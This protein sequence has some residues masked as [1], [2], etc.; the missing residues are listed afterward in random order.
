MS[1]EQDIEEVERVLRFILGSGESGVT[2]LKL[3]GDLFLSDKKAQRYID[4][5]TRVGLIECT[6]DTAFY[7]IT[8]QGIEW[9]QENEKDGRPLP[10]H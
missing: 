8:P 3:M 2:R 4:L 10:G 1:K 7:K 9:P 5:I 6:T